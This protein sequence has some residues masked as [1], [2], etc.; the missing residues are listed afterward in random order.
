M[1]IAIIVEGKTETAFKQKLNE[2]LQTKL[3]GKMPSLQFIP[4][5]G[6]IPTEAKLK[7]VVE[8]LIKDRKRPANAVIAITDVYT[9]SAPP[10]FETADDAKRKMREWVGKEERF[11]PHVALHDFEAWLLP[12]WSKIQKLTGSNKT[13]PGK[14]PET[15]NHGNPPAY[16][17]ADVYRT[18]S[19]TKSYKKTVDAGRILE[20]EDLTVAINA[21]S[22]LK[23]LVNTIL[24]LCKAELIE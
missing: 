18:G 7:R 11:H 20:G 19:K 1:R 23:S 17:L 4:F 16:R 8:Q 15:V 6:R 24:S 9:G 13:V 22:E 12:Y 2:F 14:N 5:N 3:P 10:E 21:C